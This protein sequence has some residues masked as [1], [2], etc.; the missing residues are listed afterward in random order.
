LG[1][2]DHGWNQKFQGQRVS[3]GDDDGLDSVEGVASGVVNEVGYA[4]P[5][6]ETG[7]DADENLVYAFKVFCFKG[8]NN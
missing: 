4:E 7:D 1:P 8:S 6:Q 3:E 2:F 5:N